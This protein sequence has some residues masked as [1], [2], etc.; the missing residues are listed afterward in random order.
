MKVRLRKDNGM[1]KAKAGDVINATPAHAAFL[2]R[3]GWADPVSD[4]E[5]VETPEKPEKIISDILP[6]V[7]GGPA[8]YRVIPDRREAIRWAVEN[9]KDGDLILLC[10]KGHEDYQII[11][12]EKIHT[13]EREIVAELLKEREERK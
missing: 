2:I 10:G 7:E 9:H 6:G 4:M 5:R 1:E 8:P 12:H 3:Y 13:D 11:G